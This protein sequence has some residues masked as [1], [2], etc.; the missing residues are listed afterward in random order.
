M[1][2]VAGEQIGIASTSYNGREGEKRTILAIDRTDPS[3]PVITLDEAL[4]F[5]HFAATETFGS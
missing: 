2:W 3:K 5:K 1:D 4:E